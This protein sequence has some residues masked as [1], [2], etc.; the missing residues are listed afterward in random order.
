M[1]TKCYINKL[2]F[3][4]QINQ[5]RTKGKKIGKSDKVGNGFA[6]LTS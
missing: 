1:V 3:N 4:P 6:D 2:L 5:N